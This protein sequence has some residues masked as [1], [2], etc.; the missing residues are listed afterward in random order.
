MD[1]VNIPSAVQHNS[2]NVER[3]QEGG[4]KT[5]DKLNVFIE[6]AMQDV[7]ELRDVRSEVFK[8]EEG[9]ALINHVAWTDN[10]I[11]IASNVQMIGHGSRHHGCNL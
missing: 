5:P 3:G 8:F 6:L 1:F 7:V 10:I 4:G 11:V 9:G 2:F